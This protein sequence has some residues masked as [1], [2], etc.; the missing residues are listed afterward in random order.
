LPEISGI[1][2]L[3]FHAFCLKFEAMDEVMDHL[4]YTRKCYNPDEAPEGLDSVGACERMSRDVT[5]PSCSSGRQLCPSTIILYSLPRA[6][7]AIWNLLS[8]RVIAFWM[9]QLNAKHV[10][11]IDWLLRCI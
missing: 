3:N 10:E 7:L 8:F 1:M 4:T 9:S 2:Q 5:L 6:V 11:C